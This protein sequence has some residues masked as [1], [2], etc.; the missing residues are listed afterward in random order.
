MASIAIMVGGAVLNAATFFCGNYLVKALWGGD[1][2][3][4]KEKE[5]Y[6]RALEAYQ[7]AYAKYTHDRTKRLDWIATSAQRKAEAKQNFTNT[8]YA[9]KLYTDQAHPVERMI[10][11]KESKLSDFYQ[12]SGLQK[13]GELM[14]VGAGTLALGYAAIRFL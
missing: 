11:P 5:R 10:P 14:L 2:A 3:A 6:D 9:L 4:E 8:D 7:A 1:T 12:P 13:K